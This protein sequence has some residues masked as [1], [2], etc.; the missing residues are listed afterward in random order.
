MSANLTPDEV[1]KVAHLARLELTE[2]E[3]VKFTDQLTSILGHVDDIAA[4]DI[5]ELPTT[6]HPFG[7]I[8][9]LRS[10]EIR[11]SVDRDE[12][13]SQAP[14]AVDGRFGVPR[15]MGEAP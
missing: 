12:V 14:K 10:D 3:V 8:N 2:A 6:A 15:I 9:V 13:L 11:P 7:L 5:H 1:L 4:L